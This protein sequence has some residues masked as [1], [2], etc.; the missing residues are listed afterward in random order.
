M[1]EKMLIT[2][3]QIERIVSNLNL[4]NYTYDGNI[5]RF[6]LV[7]NPHLIGSDPY[8]DVTYDNKFLTYLSWIPFCDTGCSKRSG[9]YYARFE[10][11]K[12]Q[13]P[14]DLLVR[15]KLL[16]TDVDSKG[17]VSSSVLKEVDEIEEERF[18]GGPPINNITNKVNEVDEY[19]ERVS[20]G[21]NKI[22]SDLS[23]YNRIMGVNGRRLSSHV[24]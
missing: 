8:D 4:K 3:Y 2:N 18:W 1:I 13:M 12:F 7:D 5:L 16:K 10:S 11:I 24:K 17:N 21:I 19:Q 14:M 6:S 9:E 20:N 22:L 15:N 23:E